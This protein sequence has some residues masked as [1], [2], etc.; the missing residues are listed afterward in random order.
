MTLVKGKW[1][2]TAPAPHLQCA[3]VWITQFCL[4]ITSYVPL[5]RKRSLDGATTDCIGRNLIAA[6]YLFID[7]ER[8]IG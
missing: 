1:I 5:P 3:Q 2:Y 4:Q 7:P 8:M 6:Y